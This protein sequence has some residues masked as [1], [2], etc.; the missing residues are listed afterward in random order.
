M[1][2]KQALVLKRKV[3]S[4]C[5]IL[6]IYLFTFGVFLAYYESKIDSAK[7]NTGIESSVKTPATIK[8]TIKNTFIEYTD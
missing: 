4:Y 5:V 8:T 2:N 6:I 3:A 1:E 7:G